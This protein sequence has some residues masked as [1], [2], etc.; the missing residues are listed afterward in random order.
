M[1]YRMVQT[2]GKTSKQLQQLGKP[3]TYQACVAPAELMRLLLMLAVDLQ[4]HGDIISLQEIIA[5]ML[6]G[7]MSI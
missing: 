6:S 2:L 4:M 5:P 3:Q 7:D 1:S